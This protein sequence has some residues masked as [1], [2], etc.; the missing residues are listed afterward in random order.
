ML[1]WLLMIWLQT[2]NW[3]D[4]ILCYAWLPGVG[5]A[6]ESFTAAGLMVQLSTVHKNDPINHFGFV[7][8]T[9]QS[10]NKLLDLLKR[11]SLSCSACSSSPVL[12]HGD[13]GSLLT[14]ANAPSCHP[15]LPA[16]FPLLGPTNNIPTLRGLQYSFLK[17]FE[18]FWLCFHLLHSHYDSARISNCVTSPGLRGW[19]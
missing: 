14:I 3:Q 12:R 13:R 4:L 16:Q 19:L 1:G 9:K 7:F 5:S 6:S 17:T 11:C 8:P 18:L 2:P 15:P 10:Q